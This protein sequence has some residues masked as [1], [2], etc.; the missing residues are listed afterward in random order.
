MFAQYR[1]G[2]VANISGEGGQLDQ[3]TPVFPH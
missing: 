2:H 3:R 1:G